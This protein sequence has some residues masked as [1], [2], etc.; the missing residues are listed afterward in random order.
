MVLI[1]GARY[2]YSNDVNIVSNKFAAF[3]PQK[4]MLGG[5]MVKGATNEAM[6]WSTEGKVYGFWT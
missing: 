5:F 3:L 4:A 2:V 1:L 6:E